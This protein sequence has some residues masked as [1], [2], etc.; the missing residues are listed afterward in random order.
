MKISIVIPVH[1]EAENIADLIREI[2]DR[3]RGRHEYE[4]IIVDDGSSDRT[5]EILSEQQQ[6]FP[7]VVLL[8]HLKRYGQSAA[9]LT[10]IR[11]AA[12]PLIVSMDGDGQNDPKDIDALLKVYEQSATPS[13]SVMVTG[14]RRHRHDTRWRQFSSWIAN[15]IR[16]LILGDKTRDSGCGLKVFSHE[17]FDRLPT[18]D[19]MHRFLPSLALCV[20]GKTISVEVNHRSRRQGQS[21][22]GTLDRLAAGIVDLCG[23]FWLMRRRLDPQTVGV[24][25]NSSEQKETLL[26]H[27]PPDE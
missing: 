23:V 4:V 15:T 10:G 8:R 7:E 14:Y 6:A 1:N 3:L 12:H 25:P 20:G 19:H 22:Y 13:T 26:S 21:H 16:S 2:N 17:L 18:F 9:L 5:Q 11:H 27:C 24:S